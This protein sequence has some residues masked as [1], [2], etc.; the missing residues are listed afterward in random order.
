[1]IRKGEVL[2]MKRNVFLLAIPALLLCYTAYAEDP[3]RFVDP[4]L[5]IEVETALGVTNP[6]LGDML[7]LYRL[8]AMSKGITD[9]TGLEYAT[10]LGTL[11]LRRNQISDISPLS[12]LIN[13]SWLGIYGNQI[14]DLSP[15]SSLTNLRE[16]D[17]G[18][19]EISDISA[20]SNL[21]NLTYLDLTQNQISDVNA[22]SNLTNLTRL[23]LSQN[24]VADISPLSGLTNLT[25]L[26]I[27]MNQV[28]DINSLSALTSLEGLWLHN[29]QITDVGILAGFTNLTTLWLQQNPLNNN[30]YCADLAAIVSNNPSLT[31]LEYTPNS[32][33]P[34]GLS[35]SDGTYSDKVGI[36]WN[37]QCNGPNYTSFYQVYRA[38]SATGAKSAISLWQTTT[39][40]D[41][42]SATAGNTYTYWVQ[43]A[44]SDQGEYATDFSVPDTGY[45]G[46][47]QTEPN[48]PS[49]WG[50]RP[51]KTWSQPPMEINPNIDSAPLFCGWSEPARSTERTGQKRQWRMDADDFRC[52][53]P[54]PV[55]RMR[56]WGGYKAWGHPELPESQPDVWHI[57]FWANQIEDIPRNEAFPERIVWSLDIP[58][59]RVRFEP[60]GLS[61]FPQQTPTMC[62]VYEVELEPE[63]WFGQAEFYSNE[64]VFWISITAVYAA[65]VEQVNMWGWL[66]RPHL[67][68]NGAVMPSLMGDWPTY[69]ERLFPGR[70]YPIENSAMCGQNQAYDLCF[71]LQTEQPWVKWSQSFTGS[72]EWPGYKG[73]L[74]MA[75]EPEGGELS[76]LGQVADDWVCEGRQ[77]VNAVAWNGSYIGCEYRTCSCEEKIEPRRPDYFLLSI[78]TNTQSSDTEN[79]Q[80]PGEKV[81][82]Y[83]AFDYDEVLVGYEGNLNGEPSDAIFRYSVRL[84]EDA[85]FRPEFPESIYWLSITAVFNEPIDEIP[86]QWGWTNHPHTFG[87]SALAAEPSQWQVCLDMNDDPVDMSF[88][89]FTA[90]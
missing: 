54:A 25:S 57:D 40:F 63:E 4:N 58:A 30:A 47:E 51:D 52:P 77:P 48:L 56:W 17:P 71:E 22:L 81:W 72:R 49:D 11:D 70:I 10:N 15:L 32:R 19:N 13:L 65:D 88:V 24:Q 82:E 21:T 38:D 75:F 39:S 87:T 20:I 55:T 66:T 37:Q 29:N 50:D 79:A 78:R 35:A 23:Y 61:E 68:G 69:D 64:D 62:F 67:W 9:I 27:G 90:P 26:D 7:L 34:T 59:E 89:L 8:D 16:L 43:A 36:T 2:A 1:M 3:V 5:K 60:V 46:I 84:P 86:Y 31:T 18:N 73:E 76:I 41:D 53:G 45:F 14:S 74:S 6:T 44:T 28:T 85:W 80:R 33:P 42:T 12:G 83:A